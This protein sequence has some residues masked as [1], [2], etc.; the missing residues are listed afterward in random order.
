MSRSILVADVGATT[1]RLAIARKDGAL[2]G[3]RAIANNKS[4]NLP[5]MLAEMLDE[6]G[7]RRPFG[8]VLAV[9]GPVDGDQITLTNRSWSFSRRELAR[10][11]KLKPLVVVNDFTAV[12]HVLPKFGPADLVAVGGGRGEPRGNLLVCGPGSGFGVAA[13]MRSGGKPRAISSEAGH[14]RLGAA[15]ADEARIVA[16]LVR[17]YGPAVIEHVLS[18]PGLVR[19]HRFLA[20]EQSSTEAIIAAARVGNSLARETTDAFLRLFG[21]IAGDLALAFNALGGVYLAGGLGRALES[22][23]PSSPF[24]AAFEEHPPYQGRLAL[25][26]IHVVVHSAPGLVGAAEIGRSL[27]R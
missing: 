26:P 12:A 3:V 2:E 1:T 15:T 16:H 9:A 19:L 11:L 22:L 23:V 10:T 7:R 24:R 6:A 4:E 25:I 18:G 14:M 13:L 17:E 8:A 27:F 5:T 21:R 20:G